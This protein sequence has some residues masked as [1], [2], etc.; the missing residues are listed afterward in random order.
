MLPSN[1]ALLRMDCGPSTVEQGPWWADNAF[2]V[3]V[4]LEN[5]VLTDINYDF[6]D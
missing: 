3:F 6:V 5:V 4:F 1:H 2:L